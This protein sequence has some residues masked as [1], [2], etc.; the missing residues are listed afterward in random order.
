[1][2]RTLLVDADPL[3]GG[4]DLVLGWE[5]LEGLRWPALTQTDG[6]VDPPALVQALPRRGDLGVLSWDRGELPEV[7]AEAM[8][9]TTDA[10]GPGPGH[11]GLAPLL[12]RRGG[13]RATRH[14][15]GLHRGPRRAAGHCRRRAGRRGG[16]RALRRRLRDRPWPGA[17]ADQGT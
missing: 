4:L 9:A 5:Q 12:R 16:Q 6:R 1:G 14:G 13:G 17:G 3:G 10:G 11:R 7:P 15:P 2:L 8:A